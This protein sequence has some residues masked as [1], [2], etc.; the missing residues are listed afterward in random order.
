[1]QPNLA[2][3]LFEGKGRLASHCRIAWWQSWW[4]SAVVLHSRT[5]WRQMRWAHWWRWR[6]LRDLQI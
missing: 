3:H 4:H 5:D 1:M 6:R 2:F